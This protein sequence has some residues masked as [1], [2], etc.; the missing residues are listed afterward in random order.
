MQKES[1]GFNYSTYVL[2]TESGQQVV[3]VAPAG[4]E[5]SISV[6]GDPVEL[7]QEVEA[8]LEVRAELIGLAVT[9]DISA[10]MLRDIEKKT[11]E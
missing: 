6:P 1:Q 7:H 5:V 2:T 9:N 10:A 3:A 11:T 4:V 8:N